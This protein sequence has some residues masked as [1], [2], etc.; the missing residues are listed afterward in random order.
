[1]RKSHRDTGAD[2]VPSH[3]ANRR[4]RKGHQGRRDPPAIAVT[5]DGKTA[6]V[7]SDGLAPATAVRVGAIAGHR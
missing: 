6:R 3:T 2:Q 4:R 1:M 5:P 7:A